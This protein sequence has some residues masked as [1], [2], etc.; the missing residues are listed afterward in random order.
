MALRAHRGKADFGGHVTTGH[1]WEI[2]YGD[3]PP[4]PQDDE[5]PE[6]VDCNLEKQADDQGDDSG[7][8]CS[9]S[10]VSTIV[11]GETYTQCSGPCES[12][13][14][15]GGVHGFSP[16]VFKFSTTVPE[17]GRTKAAAGRWQPL[18]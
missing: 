7:G 6:P 1:G 18:H 4:E 17:T 5:E 9:D 15:K 14:P 13:C 16:E 3:A 8:S 2:R 11:A 10:S 12:K